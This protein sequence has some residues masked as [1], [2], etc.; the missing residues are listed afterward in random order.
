MCRL[1]WVTSPEPFDPT[2]RLRS[3]AEVCRN[4]REYQ[5]HGWGCAAWDGSRWS[6]YRNIRPVWEDEWPAFPAVTRLLAH[7]RS[8]FRDEGIAV[9]NNMPFSDGRTVFAF[10]GE[11]HGVRLRSEGR[12]GAEKIYNL[13]RGFDRGDRF[14]ALR[15]A[16]GVIEKRSR[17]V[18][19]MNIVLADGERAWAS[20]LFSESPD[21]FTLH[22][23]SEN[24][25]RTICSE[26]FPGEAGWEPL[27]NRFMGEV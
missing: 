10:N 19:A 1:L 18:R 4:S 23:K 21:Y 22:R 25:V 6:L 27:D 9:E 2:P 17:Y 20:S 26:P 7:A 8:A 12:I 11:L 5:G 24:G 13:I 14:E 15:R 16:V 3:F